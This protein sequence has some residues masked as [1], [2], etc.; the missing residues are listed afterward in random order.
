MKTNERK[1]YTRQHTERLN[2]CIHRL[3]VMTTVL[4]V[5]DYS[6]EQSQNI[7]NLQE[8][9]N[10]TC[11]CDI[12]FA[13]NTN[14][15]YKIQVP[16]IIS[17]MLNSMLINSIS[18]NLVQVQIIW[19]VSAY[20]AHLSWQVLDR[21]NSTLKLIKICIRQHYTQIYCN[22]HHSALQKPCGILSGPCDTFKFVLFA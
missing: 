4:T 8:H 15:S 1:R 13:F 11:Y 2:R 6:T 9:A 21:D 22:Q 16:D 7:Q 10:Q 20:H 18:I 3:V 17:F 12:R 14:V 5:L 19:H